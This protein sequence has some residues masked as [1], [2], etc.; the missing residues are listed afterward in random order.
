MATPQDKSKAP[1]RP[2]SASTLN[3]DMTPLLLL[4][5]IDR[6]PAGVLRALA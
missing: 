3:R 6:D 1:T 4:N 5:L 2:R